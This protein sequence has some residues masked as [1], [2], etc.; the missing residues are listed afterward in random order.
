MSYPAISLEVLVKNG[1][2]PVVSLGIYAKLKIETV[3]V[4]IL[5]SLY[6]ILRTTR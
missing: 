3:P 5:G 4:Y 6:L 2:A 1:E